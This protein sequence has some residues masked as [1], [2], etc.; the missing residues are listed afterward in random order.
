MQNILQNQIMQLCT[1]QTRLIG[2]SV[3]PSPA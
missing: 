1:A 3:E 2:E